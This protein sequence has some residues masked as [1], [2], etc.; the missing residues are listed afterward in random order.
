ME[1]IIVALIGLV[2]VVLAALIQHNRK[3]DKNEH[4]MLMDTVLRV[5]TKIDGH[6]TDHAKGN[7]QKLKT[8]AR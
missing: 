4:G 1:A 5:E 7:F 3:E 2:G 8:K 6:I